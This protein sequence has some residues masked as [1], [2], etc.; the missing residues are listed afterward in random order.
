MATHQVTTSIKM[1]EIMTSSYGG[2]THG[3]D[4]DG[5]MEIEFEDLI[6]AAIFVRNLRLA[7]I[8]RIRSDGNGVTVCTFDRSV[9]LEI[10][11]SDLE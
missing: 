4:E 9:V 8:A 1:I 3:T 10:Q 5:V 6:H 11:T 2:I 7:P